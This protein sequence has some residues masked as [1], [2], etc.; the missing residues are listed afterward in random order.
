MTR[1][2]VRRRLELACWQ[3]LAVALAP[4]L[5]FSWAFDAGQALIPML[6][7]PVFIAGVASMF[8]RLPRF[9]A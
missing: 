1:S 8:L 9:G 3:Y 7:M 6:S 2:Q 5:V 4:L